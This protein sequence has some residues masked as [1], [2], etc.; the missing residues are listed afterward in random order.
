MYVL[1]LDPTLTNQIVNG[2]SKE[3]R[4]W[5]VNAIGSVVVA[6]GIVEPNELIAL[7]EAIR[8]LDSKEEAQNLMTLVK[9]KKLYEIEPIKVPIETGASLFFYIASIAVVDGNLKKVEAEVLI[10]VAK[11]LG[12][13]KEFS[14]TVM[15]WAHR[16]MEQNR[17][18]SEEQNR[19]NLERQQIIDSANLMT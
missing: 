4:D 11:Q 3:I 19:L 13:P 15:R 6:D 17:K 10:K 2:L 8:L 5:V 18:W 1:R 16:Q 9:Q 14:K 7:Q 12:L